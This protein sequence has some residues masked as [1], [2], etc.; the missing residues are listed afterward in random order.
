MSDRTQY[1]I[2][3]SIFAALC[4]MFGFATSASGGSTSPV[5]PAATLNTSRVTYTPPMSCG[6]PAFNPTLGGICQE[7]DDI[8]LAY[9]GMDLAMGYPTDIDTAEIAP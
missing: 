2:I 7:L 1:R 6:D 8:D 3:L 4:L 5:N 9:L